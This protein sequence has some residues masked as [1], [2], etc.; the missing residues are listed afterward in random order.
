MKNPFSGKKDGPEKVRPLAGL[1]K[2]KKIIAVIIV[3]I[4]VIAAI[5]IFVRQGI[6]KE[7]DEGYIIIDFDEQQCSIDGKTLCDMGMV[8]NGIKGGRLTGTESEYRGAQYILEQFQGAG[9]SEAHIEEYPVL[10][11]NPINVEASLVPYIFNGPLDVGVP[12]PLRPVIEYTHVIDFVIQG[13][14]GSL[15]WSNNMDDLDIV[16]IGDGRDNSDYEGIGGKA[17]IVRWGGGG[18][19]GAP[20]NSELFFKAWE[21]GAAAIILHNLANGAE[22]NYPPIFKASPLPER[23]P[24]SNYPDIP[25]FMVSKD[26]GDEISHLQS[27]HKIRLNFDIPIGE[28]NLN[29]VVGEIKGTTDELIL[30][31]AHHDTVYNGPGGID[32][33]VGTIT[34]IGLARALAKYTPKKTI[35]LCT[36]GGEEEGLF[37]SNLY[38]EAHRENLLKNCVEML[39]FDMD[40]VDLERGNSLPIQFSSNDTVEIVKEIAAQV[41]KVEKFQKYQV[42][43]TWSSLL[44]AGSDQQV[45][46]NNGIP[47]SSTWGSGS[48]EYHTH[49]DIAERQNAESQ[50][51][52][53]KI[54]GSYALYAANQ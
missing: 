40:N 29:V 7:R 45:F 43:V 16:N 32:N 19:S 12:N 46:A 52:A 30:L 27:D 15:H 14:S 38:F 33:T 35:R 22:I 39:N 6:F 9:L 50:A 4:I 51:L 41:Q 13:Y 26:V 17:V 24:D 48:W 21:N 49:L 25:F 2:N 18:S 31:G 28:T 11:F 1:V 42:P 54:V 36:F 20:G 5:G 3:G 37:G 47:V 10:M 23:W 34:I 53:A 8:N 44:T